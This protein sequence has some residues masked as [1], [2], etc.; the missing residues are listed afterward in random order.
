MCL[1]YTESPLLSA[2]SANVHGRAGSE[3]DREGPNGSDRHRLGSGQRQSVPHDHRRSAADSPERCSGG[4]TW[5]FD[6]PIQPS[7]VTVPI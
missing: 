5:S 6:S 1:A 3:Q 2:W 4:T 7:E